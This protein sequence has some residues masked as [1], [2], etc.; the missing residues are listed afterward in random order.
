MKA[1]HVETAFFN[2]Y[3]Q[4]LEQIVSGHGCGHIGGW[5]KG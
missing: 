2:F 4:S 1:K 3:S 5:Y